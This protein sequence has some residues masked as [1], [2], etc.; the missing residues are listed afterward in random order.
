[1]KPT[2]VLLLMSVVTLPVVH[3]EVI[4]SSYVV[5]EGLVPGAAFIDRILPAPL[6]GKLRSDVWGGDNVLPRDASNGIEA[7]DYSY[8]GGNILK[9]EDDQYHMFVCRWPEDNVKGGGRASGHQ[10]WWSSEVVHAISEDPIGPY[11]VVDV[12]GAGHN[13]EIYQRKDGSYVIGVMGD[14]AYTAGSLDGPWTEIVP[15]FEWQGEPLNRTNRTYIPREDGSLLMM[16]KNGYIFISENGDEHFKQLTEA[17]VYPKI[18]NKFEDPVIWKDE[19]QYHLIVNDWQRRYALYMRSPDGIHW[20]WAPGHAY[21]AEVMKLE[22]GHQE[23]WYKFE[24]P[25][26]LQDAYGRATHI[27]FAVIDVIKDEDLANDHHS[28][29]NV[30]LPLLVPRRIQIMNTS[31]ITA[32]T[33]KIELLILAE[34]G[35]DPITEV[36]VESLSFG[37]PEFVDFGKG[38]Q[39]LKAIAQ[40]QDLLVVF[41]GKGN[42]LEA[43][44]FTAKLLGKN[45]HGELLLGYAKQPQK[46]RIHLK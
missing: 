41:D 5:P 42:G 11:E 25:K 33:S 19:V 38:S 12:I 27:N 21:D 28:S 46:Q 39:S 16:N 34:E 3:S 4:K 23:R 6:K 26:V 9:G 36:D 14:K 20:K 24:R 18:A 35:F 31:R 13:P 10:T 30:V 2:L 45:T 29:K 7:A 43:H 1:M 15:H 40:G 8:W 32:E 22:G 44:N 17:S 37:A